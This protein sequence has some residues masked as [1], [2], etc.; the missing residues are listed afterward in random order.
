VTFLKRHWPD[1]LIA[2]IIAALLAGFAIVLFGNDP[3]VTDTP[4]TEPSI[5]A[6]VQQAETTDP[7]DQ[8]GSAENAAP[9]TSRADIPKAPDEDIPTIPSQGAVPPAS[10]A[11]RSSAEAT[12]D[13]P[14]TAPLDTT[15]PAEQEAESSPATPTAGTPVATSEN[16]VPTRAD[17]RLSAGVFS[18]E[19]TARER[20]SGI[21]ELGYTVHFITVPQGVVAQIGPFADRETAARAASDIGKAYPGVALYPPVTRSPTESPA[22]APPTASEA[23]RETTNV[24]VYLQVGAFDQAANAEPLVEKLRANGYT[25]TVNAPP[26]R[27][28]KVLVGPFSGDALITAE[29]NLHSLGLEH[30]RVR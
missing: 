4:S 25:P 14:T 5:S 15:K 19:A 11:D 20:T 30:F 7:S 8:A 24:P 1:M 9:A 29:E 18:S 17:Y 21:A 10:D 13:A 6:P 2:S 28:A 12:E 3:R 27:K 23:P 22:V 16:R 26:G